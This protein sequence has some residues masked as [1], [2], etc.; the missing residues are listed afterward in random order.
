MADRVMRMPATDGAVQ[1]KCQH[2]EEEDRQVHRKETGSGA[3][4]ADGRFERYASSL[5]D[6]G[7]PLPQAD[8]DFFEP[9]FNQD[10][11]NVRI[12]TGS[13]AA[14]S[15]DSIQARAYTTGRH[16]VFNT[17][18]YQPGSA[19][20]RRLMAHEL[21]H[22]V[23]QTGGG[24]PAVQRAVELRPPGRGEASAFERRQEMVD[25]LN[26]LSSAVQYTLNGRV[27]A[28]E[29]VEGET[30]TFFDRQMMAFIDNEAVLPLRL[31]TGAGLV[32]D[33]TNGFSTLLIDSFMT[34]YLDLEDMMAS[35][36]TSFQMNL[37]HILTE[38][39]RARNYARRIGSPGLSPVDGA[40]NITPEFRRAHQ[41][42]MDAETAFLRDVFDDPSIRFV[43]ETARG[44]TAIFTFRSAEGYRI[45]H[46]FRHQ[47]R[48][49]S[50]G[51]VTVINAAG[52][53][54]S[55]ADFIERRRAVAP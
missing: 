14:Q 17:G 46:T 37:L 5:G 34:G 11:S 55:V 4:E 27:L 29:V 35:D 18:Q 33:R 6:R 44:T 54:V 31:I 21:T 42:G 19:P 48:A 43:S 52:E 13:D 50:G 10:F 2:C 51:T 20:G 25:R 1:R 38:R 7:T 45:R 24:G 16:I 49:I 9:R 26:A 8:R 15:A 22:I 53:T 30:P 23:Q 3:V 12:H 32:G 28:Y 40:G 36:D 47:D 41:A 39:S